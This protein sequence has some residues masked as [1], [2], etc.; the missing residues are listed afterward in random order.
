MPRGVEGKAS[1]PSFLSPHIYIYICICI[2]I[3]MYIYIYIRALRGWPHSTL[4]KL[5][6]SNFCWMSETQGHSRSTSFEG[7]HRYFFRSALVSLC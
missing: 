7:I 6:R 4:Q 5:E 1:V 3:Y 2:Y